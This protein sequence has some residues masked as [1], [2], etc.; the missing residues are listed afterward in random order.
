MSLKNTVCHVILKNILKAK[1]NR[2]I[3]IHKAVELGKF[4]LI[5]NFSE[6][7]KVLL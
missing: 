6:L 4:T 7:F 1:I 5:T 2:T 3:S